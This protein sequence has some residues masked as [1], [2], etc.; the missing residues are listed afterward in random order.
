MEGKPAAAVTA[1][2]G[3][4]ANERRRETA[5]EK[6]TPCN[7]AWMAEDEDPLA[8]DA[9]HVAHNITI[10]SLKAIRCPDATERFDAI[11]NLSCKCP[12]ALPPDFPY[13]SVEVTDTADA[14]VILPKLIYAARWV[15]EQVRQQPEHRCHCVR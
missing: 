5:A 7:L 9:C 15:V 11:L 3:K 12:L 14:V 1:R 13:C 4:P 6:E 8:P 10:G 2:N